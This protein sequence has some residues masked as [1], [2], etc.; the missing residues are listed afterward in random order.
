MGLHSE[1]QANQ[2]R[3][4]RIQASGLGV[5]GEQR[6][7]TQLVQPGVETG[8]IEDGFVL[9][10][11]HFLDHLGNY[12]LTGTLGVALYFV[13]PA[14]ELH[15]AVQLKQ[16]L[17]IRLAADQRVD[18]H[19]QRYID[20]DRRQ[21]IG[22]EGRIAV[23]FKLG[24]QGLGAT[25][26]Q[27]GH[28][29]EVL[30]QVA[31]TA[32]DTSQQAHCRLFTYTRHTGN[33]IDLVAHESEEIDDVLRTDAELL[34]YARDI[35]HSS[36]HGIDQ[37]NVAVDQLR[38][39]LVAGRDNHR[40]SGRGTAAGQGADHVVGL[41]AFNTQQ[42]I[43]QGPNAGMQRLDLHAQVIRHAW[44]VGFVLGEHFVAESATFGVEHHRKQAVRILFAQ[45]FEHVQ[46]A[47][48]RT[49][50][51]ALGSSQRRQRVKGAVEV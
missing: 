35:K 5:E 15:L 19:L 42:R 44:S 27:T 8:L 31:Q 46:H 11:N 48:D 29:V 36:S 9:G 34:V 6:R 47:L 50:R 21:L 28:L 10:L 30:V 37:R 40:T 12:L 22:E 26:S 18:L 3:L 41:D 13:D 16:R 14:L 24:R 38:H 7:S 17:A 33:V 23:F 1:R 25:D 4:L 43:A 32:T 20:L 45:A 39:V 2:L 51:H 49:G